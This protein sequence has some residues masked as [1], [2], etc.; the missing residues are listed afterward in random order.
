LG[1][2]A[3]RQHLDS[4]QFQF[5]GFHPIRSTIRHPGLAVSTLLLSLCAS[6]WIY[7]RFQSFQVA[8]YGN[9]QET[10]AVLD[11][12]TFFVQT[13]RGYTGESD[14]SPNLS[15]WYPGS[16]KP[17]GFGELNA[18]ASEGSDTVYPPTWYYKLGFA[19]EWAHP[20][21]IARPSTAYPAKMYMISVPLWL[22]MLIF[23]LPLLR[24]Y[25][26]R[27][28]VAIDA[29]S[30]DEDVR[31]RACEFNRSWMKR[32]SPTGQNAARITGLQ[33][34]SAA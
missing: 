28:R 2:C 16:D 26:L 15:R 21:W 27:R 23:S 3:L 1:R 9:W 24:T 22:L 5:H 11:R 32:V 34:S 18:W 8:Y 7:T 30:G 19:F 31:L 12:G 17:G 20:A 29:P 13:E 6:A 10:F 4:A 33:A 25:F 14:M